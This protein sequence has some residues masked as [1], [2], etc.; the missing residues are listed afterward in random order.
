V[1]AARCPVKRRCAYNLLVRPLGELFP[2]LP[3]RFGTPPPPLVL[4]PRFPAG[5]YSRGTVLELQVVLV[6]RAHEGLRW[7]VAGLAG[8]GRRG[9]G[10]ARAAGRLEGCFEVRGVDAIGPRGETTLRDATDPGQA[11]AHP[12]R[13]PD[14]F[15]GP[16]PASTTSGTFTLDLRSPTLIARSPAPHGS[17]EFRDL[18]AA[19]GKRVSLLSM[20]HGDRHL[21]GFDEHC[22]LQARAAEVRVAGR[23]CRWEEWSRHSRRQE[24]SFVVGGWTG[25]VR[26]AGQVAPFVPLLRLGGLLHVGAHTIRGFGEAVLREGM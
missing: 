15:E 7:V 12:W 23:G 11:A 9:V 4:R 5:T 24:R 20:T 8:A 2:E 6:G 14:D 19:L 22:E 21:L 13:F 17:F 25:W 18:V 16:A 26:Y 3:K 1:A 10:P